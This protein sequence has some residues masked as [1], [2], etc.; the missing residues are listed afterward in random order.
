MS[1][2]IQVETKHYIIQVKKNYIKTI[3]C[4]NYRSSPADF[5]GLLASWYNL[6]A[7]PLIHVL[8]NFLH[9]AP[10]KTRATKW[11]TCSLQCQQQPSAI[12]CI[13]KDNTPVPWLYSW[14][15]RSFQFSKPCKVLWPCVVILQDTPPCWYTW[16]SWLVVYVV[17]WGI[18]CIV[19][20]GNARDTPVPN[21]WNQY[22]SWV[23]GDAITTVYHTLVVQYT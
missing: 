10:L 17:Y 16:Q 22:V 20:L 9:S 4:D 7:C 14:R 18:A 2:T 11:L 21:V 6:C 15:V 23:Y 12:W 13:D 5:L 3:S 1:K 8:C 19:D